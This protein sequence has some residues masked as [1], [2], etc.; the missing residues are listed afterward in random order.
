MDK[1]TDDELR[2]FREQK[3]T[4]LKHRAQ[5]VRS[6]QAADGAIYPRIFFCTIYYTP[7]ESGFTADRGFD[8]TPVTATGL[9][10]RKYPRD[11]LFAV[12]KEGF[13][14][15]NEAVDGRNYIRWMGDKRYA[16]ADA[17]V[18]RRGEVLVP[19]RSCA[20]SSR[21]KFLRQH[22]RLRIKSQT[23]NEELAA[24]NGSFATPV[25]AC[26]RCKS[27]CIG[28]KMNRAARLD[29]N[30]LDRAAPGWNTHLR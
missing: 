21:N 30:A 26:I 4:E 19:R 11:F 29:V 23:I 27:I 22:A 18:G 7:K 20:I 17:P 10:G 5:E 9:R 15:I 16:F 14:R 6:E 25:G 2:A 13:G 1:M 12:K 24:K 3:V 8:A 28:A